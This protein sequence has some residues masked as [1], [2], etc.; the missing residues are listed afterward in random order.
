VGSLQDLRDLLA[1]ARTGGAGR[2]AVATH[3]LHEAEDLLRGLADGRITGRA[4]LIP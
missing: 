2:P 4:V 3:G 1:L